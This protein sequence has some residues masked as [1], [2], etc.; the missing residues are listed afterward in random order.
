[1]PHRWE[2]SLVKTQEKEAAAARATARK[3]NR[4]PVILPGLSLPEIRC[5]V[6]LKGECT[7]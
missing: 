6:F 1:M 2:G 3:Q 5:I 7:P 4:R